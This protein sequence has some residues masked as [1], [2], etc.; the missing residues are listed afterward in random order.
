VFDV[1]LRQMR[2]GLARGTDAQ[3]QRIADRLAHH[4]GADIALVDAHG[5]ALV[6]TAGITPDL[7]AALRPVL[8]ELAGRRLAAAA[9]EAAGLHVR[10]EALGPAAPGPVLVVA[11]PSPPARE[12]T[13][14]ASHTGTVIEALRRL[15]RADDAA[16]RYQDAVARVRV[17][18][19]MALMAGDL[20]L[21]RRM[22]VGAVPPLLDR[23]RVR[24]HLLSCP[25]GDRDPVIERFQDASGYH[26]RHLMLRCPVF[27]AHV[28]CL[29]ADDDGEGDSGLAALLRS[30]VRDTPRYALGISA[31]HP[32]AETARAY[33]Q[34]RHA[35]AA[36]RGT[37]QRAAPY[38]G[39]AP[40][41]RLLPRTAAR[42]WADAV[43]APVRPLPRLS[44][45]V[46]RLALAFPHTGV[47]R[48][49]DISRN[50]VAAHLR[51]V[52][53]ALGADLR[54]VDARADLALA[55]AVDDLAPLGPIGS[56]GP[57]GSDGQGGSDGTRPA[58]RLDALLAR[59]EAATWAETFLKPVFDGPHDPVAD[60]LRA[61]IASGTD[62]Q[63]T[64]RELGI[65][66]TT[67]RARLR[68]AER[69][70][71]RDLLVPGPGTH[72]LVHALRIAD[73]AP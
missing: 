71:N 70:L 55:L 39:A 43:L 31:P 72:D 67:V 26:G 7:I 14:L 61:W 20:A 44:L 59:E 40:L 69:L 50:T 32:L 73:R 17:A 64:S 21:A 13:A 33:E 2:R 9:T 16:R 62:A 56:D 29:V 37:P 1:L 10:C 22:T 65:N 60:T 27:D 45:D 52:E 63:R 5:R 11:A 48:L 66:R 47:A 12:V 8:A 38:Q 24:V 53:E 54:R 23:E 41:A 49:L 18:V 57:V 25:P 28:I 35:L 36:A 46:V 42:A 68:T 19:F 15:H 3:P 58:P 51:R 30:M 34:A 6:A 4:T